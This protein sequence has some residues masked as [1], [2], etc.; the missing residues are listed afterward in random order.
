MKWKLLTASLLLSFIGYSQLTINGNLGGKPATELYFNVPFSN[1]IH[2]NNDMA[3]KADE[4]GRF[5]IE[6]PVSRP[7]IFF[8]RIGKEIYYLYG[9]PKKSLSIEL[10]PSAVRASLKFSGQLGKENEFRKRSGLCF[11]ALGA[12]ITADS[13]LNTSA[14][15]LRLQR[16]QQFWLHALDKKTQRFSSVFVNNTR[17]E[18]RFFAVSWFW[19]RIWKNGILTSRTSP[20]CRRGWISAIGNA[21]SAVSISDESA[22]SSY[23]YQQAVSYYR[24]YLENRFA[25]RDSALASIASVFGLPVDEMMRTIKLKGEEYYEYSIL[26]K[27][28]SGQAREIML[29]TFLVKSAENGELRYQEEGLKR[30]KDSFPSS[31]FI[32]VLEL[33]LR[34]FQKGIEEAGLNNAGAIVFEPLDQGFADLDQIVAAHRGKVVYIDL[35]G[36][37][38]GPCREEFVHLAD[39]KKRF[40]NKSVDFVYIAKENNPEP[41]KYWK[42]MAAYYKLNG[43]HILMDKNLERYFSDLYTRNGNFSFPSYILVD[44]QGKL[45]TIRASRP[46]DKEK[47]YKEIEKLL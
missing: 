24:R 8:M 39:L 37:W 44:K 4:R 21:Y 14:A 33:S 34:G 32:P 13:S 16:E 12:E 9:E 38:C 6:L 20:A 46:S 36:T 19:D 42:Q 5:T 30:F 35:W 25:A 40:S 23:H 2:K 3:V 26:E 43:R 1:W 31:G 47:L 45:V 18:I 11:Y 41:E 27:T 15:Y 22:V 10:D 17:A 29:A 7:Q 28:L